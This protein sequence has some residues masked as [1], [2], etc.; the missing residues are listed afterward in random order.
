M[1]S[2][3]PDA[4]AS[5]YAGLPLLTPGRRHKIKDALVAVAVANL[6]FLRSSFDLLFDGD[7]YF[8]KLPVERAELLALMV[9]I[10]C[11]T[12]ILWT[13]IRLWR[14]CPRSSWIALG[15]ELAFLVLFIL[16]VDFFRRDILDITDA[17][18]VA[19]LKRLPMAGCLGIFGLLV[20]WKHRLVA[21]TAAVIAAITWPAALFTL[22][23]TL[24]LCLNVVHV[25]QCTVSQSPAPLLAARAGTPRVLWIIFDE[26]DYRLAFEQRPPP[27]K[28]PEFDRLQGESLSA[29]AAY[30]PGDST[31]YSMPALIAGRRVGGV[32]Y[33]DCDLALTMA[34]TD[35]RAEWTALPSVFSEA[36]Q[37]GVNSALVGWYH[38]YSHV[39][40]SAL[41]YC[42]WYPM[43][44]FEP[45]RSTTF[46]GSL[47]QQ[48]ASLGGPFRI[49]QIFINICQESLK[50]GAS[51]AANPAYGLILLHLP[52]PHG[53]GVY[54][55]EKNQFT[56][57][58]LNTVTGYFNNLV[59]ADKELGALREALETSGQNNKTWIIL[60]ADHSWR[61]SKQYDGKRDYRVPF[62]V[63]PP[64]AGDSRA[65]T[66]PFNTVLTHD[67]ILAILGGRLTNSASVGA[68][69][70]TQ[71]KADMPI[72][73]VGA[74]GD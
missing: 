11:L 8:N 68:W 44:L 36:R 50:E 29:E 38:P 71:G 70:D 13:G 30:A 41:S 33:D 60:S 47:F 39:L 45:A 61:T 73:P 69:L 15:L 9:N 48:I 63:R 74:T 57:L 24:L 34:D 17:A 49:R 6:C 54:L 40:G 52:P 65:Y 58:G 1:N 67:L 21:R 64:G 35:G 25:K 4:S 37:M 5:D 7:R 55:P 20:L 23:K 18:M 31:L 16:P 59:L 53:P 3:P 2:V 12:F 32:A 27:V 10:G 42:S 43:P 72:K 14:R 19:F 26:T 62:L 56:R 28:L 46:A 22:A 66:R 51:L